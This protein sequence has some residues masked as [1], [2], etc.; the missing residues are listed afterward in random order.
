MSAS[1]LSSLPISPPDV[2]P[3]F[4]GQ[5]VIVTGASRGIGRSIALAFAQAGADVVLN[6]ASNT[7]AAEAAADELRAHGRRCLLVP[8]SVA[9]PRVA[10]NLRT[11]ALEAFGRIDVL[12]NNAGI[13]RDGN[14]MMLR[15]A[16]WQEVLGVNLSG[17]FYC[18]RA[19]LPTMVAQ[20]RGVIL[21]M[22]STAGLKGRAG[23][24]N[25]A[26]SKGAVIGLTKS[27]AQEYGRHG[28]RV[29]AIA[30]GFVE[31]DMVAGVL[32][33]PEARRGFLEATPLGRF[34]HPD[35]VAGAALYLAS[36]A[37]AYVTGHVLLVNG[38]LF[39]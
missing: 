27:L 21:N 11:T 17:A 4:E 37:S 2:V 3:T 26:A 28:V 32:A 35:D 10:E 38:G 5:A 7:A 20:G 14:V 39:M 18:C 29:N 22:T 12:V 9:D 25:Y 6:Y 23:Q 15:D 31:T 33:R 8:G 30:P 19:V 13:N 34:G 36:P 1:P 24:V 16:A